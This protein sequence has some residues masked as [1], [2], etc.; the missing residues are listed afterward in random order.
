MAGLLRDWPDF[1]GAHPQRLLEIEQLLGQLTTVAAAVYS[2]S[3]TVD[4]SAAAHVT[5]SA[6]NGTAFT[7]NAPTNARTGRSI[8]FDI[9]N[10][11]G[12]T[13][14]VITWNVVFKLAGA[15]T[16]PANGKRRTIS[17]KNTDGTNWVETHRAAADI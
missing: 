10:A 7:I 11:S 14:G 3:I 15:F 4:A 13:L 17:F 2:T 1:A 16:N 8:T 5:V 6:T 12:T 9:A